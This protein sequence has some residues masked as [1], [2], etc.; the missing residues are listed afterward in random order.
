MKSESLQDDA[1]ELLVENTPVV[2]DE[3]QQMQETLAQTRAELFRVQLEYQSLQEARDQ[4]L[5]EVNALRGETQ[6]RPV[7]EKPSLSL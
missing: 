2:E 1:H 3:L 5:I 4:L 7:K 6:R